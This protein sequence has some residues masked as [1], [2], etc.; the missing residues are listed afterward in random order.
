M[1]D[2]NDPLVLPDFATGY[3]PPR[4]FDYT[5]KLD[6]Q[7]VALFQPSPSPPAGTCSPAFPTRRSTWA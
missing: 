3:R 5:L 6:P 7:L 1:P 2:P 4:F